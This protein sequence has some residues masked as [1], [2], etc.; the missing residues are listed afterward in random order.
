MSYQATVERLFGSHRLAEGYL[1][2][3]MALDNET[4]ERVSQIKDTLMM[5]EDDQNSIMV[6]ETEEDQ[7]K[8]KP[9]SPSSTI[10]FN[11]QADLK[12]SLAQMKHQ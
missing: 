9:A 12:N 2:K 1:N 8:N 6:E 5:Q 3:Q 4:R 10:V 7:G 11:S